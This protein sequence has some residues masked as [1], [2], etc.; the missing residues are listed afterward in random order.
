MEPDVRATVLR[1]YTKWNQRQQG[2]TIDCAICGE[3][4]TSDIAL[5]HWLVK[6]NAVS[7]ENHHLVDV[8]ENLVPMHNQRCH[9][10]QGQ[11]RKT[12]AKC[13]KYAAE[14][15]TATAI[16]RWYISLWQEHNLTIP[17]GRLIPPEDMP[18]HSGRKYYEIGWRL[19]GK[20]PQKSLDSYDIRDVVFAKLTGRWRVFRGKVDN[21]DLRT[22]ITCIEEGYYFDYLES[23]I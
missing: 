17:T 15:V 21:V 22:E 12:K 20:P 8:P 5:H 14:R 13:L 18:L 9:I 23:I 11:S 16:A 1:A 10:P 2:F 4:V 7:P 3:P 19:K 6:R